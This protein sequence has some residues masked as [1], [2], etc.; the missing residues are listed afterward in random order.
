M[1]FKNMQVFTIP[2]QLINSVESHN[3]IVIA[4][5]IPVLFI[6]NVN[7]FCGTLINTEYCCN[8]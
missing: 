3:Q 2:V 7:N 8:K 6:A 5:S 1:V 4:D